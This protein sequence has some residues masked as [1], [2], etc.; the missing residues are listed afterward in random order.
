MPNNQ[1]AFR[2]MN[3]LT[4]YLSE[5]EQRLA[6]LEAENTALRNALGQVRQQSPRFRTESSLP[7]TG[8][9]SDSFWVRAFTVWGHYFVA[10]LV[11]SVPVFICYM[12]FMFSVFGNLQ[13]P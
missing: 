11:I 2:N 4:A 6:T 10:Q 9:V 12:I 1:P 8:L 13:T 3:E 5:M 7:K